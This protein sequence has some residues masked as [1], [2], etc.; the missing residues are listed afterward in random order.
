MT[1]PARHCAARLLNRCA[2]RLWRLAHWIEPPQRPW[3]EA[4]RERGPQDYYNIVCRAIAEAVAE[5]RR[6]EPENDA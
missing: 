5:S 2:G 6:Y 1:R 3:T 4:E